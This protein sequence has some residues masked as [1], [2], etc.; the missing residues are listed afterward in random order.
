MEKSTTIH[1]TFVLERS[2]AAAPE[3]VFEAFADP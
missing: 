3:R 1:S 2:Y